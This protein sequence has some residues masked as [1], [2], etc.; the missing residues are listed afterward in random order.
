MDGELLLKP[1]ELQELV[2]NGQ[3]K[4]IKSFKSFP[5]LGL[6]LGLGNNALLK[7]ML[8]YLCFVEK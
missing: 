4:P 3:L 7:K 1:K 8:Q 6:R 5:F 2:K